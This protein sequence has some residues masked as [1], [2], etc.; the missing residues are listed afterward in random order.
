MLV[1]FMQNP[2]ILLTAFPKHVS[3]I[4]EAVEKLPCDKKEGTLTFEMFGDAAM[5]VLA[6]PGGR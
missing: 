5:E 3:E 1:G 2:S 4:P 6:L